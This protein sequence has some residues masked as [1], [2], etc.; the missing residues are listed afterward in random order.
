MPDDQFVKRNKQIKKHSL[1]PKRNMHFQ[2][3]VVLVFFN[4]MLIVPQ[5]KSKDGFNIY[6]FTAERRVLKYSKSSSIFKFW[7]Q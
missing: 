4:Y 6:W 1:F 5:L 3:P 2:K 7:L